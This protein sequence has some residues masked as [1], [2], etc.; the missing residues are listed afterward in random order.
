[1]LEVIME[2]RLR[3]FLLEQAR[4]LMNWVVGRR[5]FVGR[6][7]LVYFYWHSYYPKGFGWSIA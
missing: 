6:A 1:M 7:E 5:K 4:C 2:S 3:A